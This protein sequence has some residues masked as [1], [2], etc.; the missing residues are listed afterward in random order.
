MINK[1]NS[2]MV[3][4]KKIKRFDYHNT[5]KVKD[6]IADMCEWDTLLT[7]NIRPKLG[8]EKNIHTYI[9]DSFKELVNTFY[10]G[11]SIEGIYLSDYTITK[12]VLE[13]IWDYM[14][15]K[16]NCY[17]ILGYFLGDEKSP[18]NDAQAM[19]IKNE[20]YKIFSI[21]DS[22]KDIIEQMHHFNVAYAF[23]G[24][25]ANFKANKVDKKYIGDCMKNK[26]LPIVKCVIAAF[27]GEGYICFDF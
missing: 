20:C 4:D 25:V 6:Y 7:D 3:M 21:F 9:P 23:I 22:K 24:V 16:E 1:I 17:L 14:Y 27:D 5:G 15:D 2:W 10:H 12:L 11:I 13:D 19:G 8:S 26:T 18:P